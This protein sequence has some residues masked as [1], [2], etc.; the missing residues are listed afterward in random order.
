[1]ITTF[2]RLHQP[3]ITNSVNLKVTWSSASHRDVCNLYKKQTSQL[4]LFLQ[5]H[6][7]HLKLHLRGQSQTSGET[8]WPR[9][10]YHAD[11]LFSQ[12]TSA[13]EDSAHTQC[14]T[15]DA[16]ASHPLEFTLILPAWFSSSPRVGRICSLSWY[17]EVHSENTF[18]VNL[19]QQEVVW[20]HQGNDTNQ[21]RK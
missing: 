6:L 13:L 21:T 1:M 15:H 11:G 8:H 2:E 3:S 9:R 16:N 17:T 20:N 7:R 18:L 10:T 4:C 14:E 19:V 12:F 5:R